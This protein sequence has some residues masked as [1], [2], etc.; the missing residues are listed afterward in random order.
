MKAVLLQDAYQV[1]LV[2]MDLPAIGTNDVLI[3]VGVTGVCGS[4][5]H[6]YRG[7]HPFRKPPVVL[8]HEVAGEVVRAGAAVSRVRVGDRVTVEPQ[9]G[10]GACQYC[11]DGRYHLCLQKRV[12]GVRGWVGCFADYFWAPADKVYVLPPRLDLDLG[13]LVE[14]L[15]VGLHLATVGG[16]AGGKKVAVLGAGPI[17]QSAVLGARLLGATAI[18]ATDVVPSKLAV[19]EQFGARGVDASRS[20]TQGL[21]HALGGPA[22][23]VLI[24]AEYPGMLDDAL[25]ASARQSCIAVVSLFEEPVRF[26]FN[27][28]VT[29]ERT[30][31]GSMVYNRQDFDQIIAA[32]DSG[33][34]DPRPMITHRRPLSEAVGALRQVDEGVDYPIK[35]LL[36]PEGK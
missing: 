3:K 8:G 28:V 15:A 31:L 14:P 12:P 32:I 19:A 36:Y 20:V 34:I 26:D 22:D 30:L 18:A 4:D 9:Q 21:E 2:D 10:C 6:T 23:V 24:T 7:R 11:G 16:A 33:A 5:L 35:M 29:G 13:C 27:P 1:D 25:D 17:G